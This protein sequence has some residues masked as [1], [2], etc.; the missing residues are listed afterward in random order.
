MTGQVVVSKGMRQ[1][2]LP[3]AIENPDGWLLCSVIVGGRLMLGQKKVPRVF[4]S[5][6]GLGGHRCG[7]GSREAACGVL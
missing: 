5:H 3:V 1:R 2:V 7:N 6:G 4:V